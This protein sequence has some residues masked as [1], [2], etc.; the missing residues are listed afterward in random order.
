M[1]FVVVGHSQQNIYSLLIK[2]EPSC[3]KLDGS[4][5]LY[6]STDFKMYR[7]KDT[8]FMRN[9]NIISDSIRIDSLER[10]TYMIE[11]APSDTSILPS[12]RIIQLYTDLDIYLD[13]NYFNRS[14]QAVSNQ[15]KS[16]EFIVFYFPEFVNPFLDKNGHEAIDYNVLV[17]ERK[18]GKYYAYYYS[19][20]VRE[21]MYGFGVNL[22]VNFPISMLIGAPPQQKKL[23]KKEMDVVIA[24][25]KKLENGWFEMIEVYKQDT[26]K[27]ASF[28]Y[29]PKLGY[30]LLKVDKESILKLKNDLWESN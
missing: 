21:I 13:C 22:N 23:N 15:L 5:H 18:K 19:G 14:Q 1:G 25:E 24:F 26:W 27:I 16:G 10:F 8:S 2:I 12:K 29:T 6:R 11:Y 9:L 28:Y 17:V 3:S 7:R 30:T 20:I 4:L